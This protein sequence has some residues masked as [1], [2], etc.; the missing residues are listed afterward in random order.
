[1]APKV[2]VVGGTGAQGIPVIQGLVSDGAYTTRVLTR[3]LNSSRAR[4]LLDL[5]NVELVQGTFANE[6][7]LRKG[8][9]GCEYAFVNID[10]FNSGEKT[11]MFWAMRAYELAIEEGVRFFVYGNLDYG[12]KKGGYD[13]KFRTGH[14]DGK[15]RIAEWILQQTK[16]NG[17]KMG[18]AIFTTGPY[19]QMT[20]GKS[21]PMSPVVEDGVVVWR[22]PLGQG[23]VPHVSLED[24]AHY[25]R[26]LFDHQSEANGMDLEVA[27]EHVDYHELAKAFTA[28]TG[29]PAKYV[30]TDLDSYWKTGPL[31][32]GASRPAGYNADVNDLATLSM[33][34]N[35]T[36]F[37][38][39]WKFSGGNQGVVR[40]DYALL[41]RIHPKRIKSAEEWF[42]L[43]DERGRKAGLGGLYER[44]ADLKPVLKIAEDGRKGKI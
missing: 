25:V 21:T 22:V 14:Y 2:F 37:W 12:Y 4:S 31:S 29:K 41:D 33:R 5:G 42:R 17:K 3:D 39:L 19:I 1:M 34:E 15:G 13:P 10:G 9:R 40:R 43:E 27:I 7:D 6:D 32:A 38:N 18:A 24:C 30:D 8:F 35:F 36:G 16:D 26:W 23:A 44:A 20:L 11:E 28:V